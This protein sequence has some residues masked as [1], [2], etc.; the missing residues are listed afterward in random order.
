MIIPQL[1]VFLTNQPG[2][3][4]VPV[5]LLAE[6]GLNIIVLG[7]ADST[8]YG[9]LRVVVNDWQRAVEV[10]EAAGCVVNV[11]ELV[12]VD[13]ADDPGG[14][15]RVLAALEPVG[16]NIEYLYG[17]PRRCAGRSALLL[18]FDQPEQARE[19][20]RA[21]GFGLLEVAALAG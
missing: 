21:A 11:S 15:A 1:S 13:V 9:I 7:M 20:L 4:A 6:A 18:R 17:Y 5:R 16:V 19:A 14:L 8:E 10:L 3:L 12:A 2:A